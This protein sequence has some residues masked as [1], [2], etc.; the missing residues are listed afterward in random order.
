MR[1]RSLLIANRGAIARRIIRTC[2]RLGIR[3]VVVATAVD[4]DAPFAR[5]ADQVVPVSS[6]LAIP[7]IIAAAKTSRAEAIHPGYG[8]LAENPQFADACVAA[9]ITFIGPTAAAMRAAGDKVAAKAIAQQANVPTV[10][11]IANTTETPQAL[12]QHARTIGYPILVK[13]AAGGG[14][15]GMRRVSEPDQLIDAVEA[16]SRE[17]QSAFGDGRVFLEKYLVEPRHIEFQIV[18]D[19]HGHIIHLGERECSLQRR[20]QK[21]I[22]ESPSPLMTEDLRARMGEA[23]VR[24]ATA[25]GYSNVGTVEFLVDRERNFYFLEMNTRLQVEHAVTEM[26]I[27]IIDGDVGWEARGGGSLAVTN[28]GKLRFPPDLRSG[29]PFPSALQGASAPR[30]PSDMAIDLVEWQLRISGGEVLPVQQEQIAI[31]GH[32]FECRVYAEDPERQFLPC[33]GTI[34]KLHEPC[35]ANIRIESGYALGSSVTIDYDPMLAK[36]IVWGASRP[37]ALHDM[38]AVLADYIIDG[39]VTNRALLQDLV[40]APEV[41][42]GRIDTHFVERFLEGWSPTRV[43]RNDPFT[44]WQYREAAGGWRLFGERTAVVTTATDSRRGQRKRRASGDLTAPMPGRIV[45][46]L[47]QVGEQVE[48]DAVLV[49]MEAM[50]MEYAIRAPQAGTI[51]QISCQPGEQVALGTRLVEMNAWSLQH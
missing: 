11:G 2:R 48:E 7:E 12:L 18:A 45:K 14:G 28:A 5:E 42:A 40:R 16:A 10:P 34:Q 8:F 44:P 22:E 24:F 27:R 35:G 19:Q 17:A 1:C 13:A 46:V 37:H 30:L 33:T 21:I 15:K 50:K 51:T 20:H 25:V 26:V 41:A 4:R 47:V 23:A 49:V 9:G 32:A 6:Y 31:R 38:N 36:V 29:P 3:V 39:V 43:V